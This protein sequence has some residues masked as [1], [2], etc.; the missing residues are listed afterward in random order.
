ME[1][2]NEPGLLQCDVFLSLILPFHLVAGFPT[3]FPF[4]PACLVRDFFFPL[5]LVFWLWCAEVPHNLFVF[6]E[7]HLN[8]VMNVFD[9]IQLVDRFTLGLYQKKLDWRSKNGNGRRFSVVRYSHYFS[10]HRH[11]SFRHSLVMLI[12]EVCGCVQVMSLNTKFIIPSNRE[13]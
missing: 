1:C 2:S 3:L 10:H 6:N 7:S 11:V 12:H 4:L 5:H 8:R 13:C 9:L